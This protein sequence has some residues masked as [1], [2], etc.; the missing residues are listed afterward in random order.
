[1]THPDAPAK[2]GADPQTRRDY[3]IKIDWPLLRRL[4]IRLTELSP[5]VRDLVGKAVDSGLARLVLDSD[6]SAVVARAG[7]S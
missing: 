7:R 1:V 4:P 3:A 6:G 5:D 2:A